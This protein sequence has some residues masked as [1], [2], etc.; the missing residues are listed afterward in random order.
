MYIHT[1][2]ELHELHGEGLNMRSCCEAPNTSHAPPCIDVQYLPKTCPACHDKQQTKPA[3]HCVPCQF[4]LSPR[5]TGAHTTTYKPAATLQT[6]C[7]LHPTPRTQFLSFNSVHMRRHG[8]QQKLGLTH[9]EQCSWKTGILQQAQNLC[10]HSK[11]CVVTA[12]R[13][14]WCLCTH[15]LATWSC[16]LRL[17]HLCM[18]CTVDHSQPQQRSSWMALRLHCLKR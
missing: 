1:S 17:P 16:A 13:I 10:S 14:T 12:N 4:C 9:V 5:V 6:R 15:L 11:N 7:K 2:D 8:M 18:L 3:A